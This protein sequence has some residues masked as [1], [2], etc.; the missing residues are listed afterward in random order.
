MPF[1]R[2]GISAKK[3]VNSQMRLPGSCIGVRETW[4]KSVYGSIVFRMEKNT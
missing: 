2:Y 3:P 1:R 4:K